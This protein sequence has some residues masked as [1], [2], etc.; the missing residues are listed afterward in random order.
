[1]SFVKEVLNVGE[2][3]VRYS[4]ESGPFLMPPGT[5]QE[6]P[7]R[8]AHSPWLFFFRRIYLYP[9]PMRCGQMG[10]YDFRSAIACSRWDRGLPQKS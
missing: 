1:M 4:P 9:P 6:L 3:I 8:L 2:T 7:V 10:E 5:G